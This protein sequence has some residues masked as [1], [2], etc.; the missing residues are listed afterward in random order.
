M[1]KGRLGPNKPEVLSRPQGRTSD[2]EELSRPQGTG[3]HAR[4]NK[5]Q[6]YHKTSSNKSLD[7]SGEPPR[8]WLGQPPPLSSDGGRAETDPPTPTPAPKGNRRGGRSEQAR[9]IRANARRTKKQLGRQHSRQSTLVSRA[10]GVADQGAARTEAQETTLKTKNPTQRRQPT[11]PTPKST[12]LIA[13]A[14]TQS[15][16][17]RNSKSG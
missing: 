12:P 8:G 1:R 6:R 16:S 9:Q 11:P 14:S 15:P 10:P 13:A 17:D 4:P 3:Y 7:A 2:P 5:V